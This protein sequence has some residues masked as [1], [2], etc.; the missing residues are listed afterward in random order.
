MGVLASFI[1]LFAK[2]YGMTTSGGQARGAVCRE[3]LKEG[4]ISFKN[5]G[6]VTWENMEET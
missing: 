2:G 6:F 5:G 1:F 4:V 3:I